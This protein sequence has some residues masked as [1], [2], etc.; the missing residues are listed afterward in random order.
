[1][2]DDIA[3][4]IESGRDLDQLQAVA[5][6]PEH[7]ALGDK[8]RDLAAFARHARAVANLFELRDE[9]L[10]PSLSANDRLAALPIDVEIA[11]RERAAEHDALGVLTDVDEAARA[12]DPVAESADIDIALRID[13]CERKE[14]EVQSAAVIK[15]ELRRLFDHRR[16]ILTAA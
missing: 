12:D 7:G 10:V 5:A 13:L 1:M 2:R 14:R 3:L 11:G 15:I 4:G 6:D 16:E 9:F 8:E